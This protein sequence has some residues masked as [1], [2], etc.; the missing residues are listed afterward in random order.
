M[1]K[2]APLVERAVIVGEARPYLAV[3]ICC[4][5][6]AL[7]PECR[8]LGLAPEHTQEQHSSRLER[9]LL[10]RFAVLLR[11]YPKHSQ[12]RRVAI[13]TTPW[14]VDNKLLTATGKARRRQ[15]AKQYHHRIERLFGRGPAPE[16]TDFSYNVNVG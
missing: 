4:S 16:K 5:E 3:I 15:V 11:A 6:A 7:A 13:T 10:K 9:A 8:A 1:L 12:I 14:T 2:L